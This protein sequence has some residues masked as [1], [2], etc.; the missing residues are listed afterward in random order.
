MRVT[1]GELYR[2]AYGEFAL[3]AYN[4]NNM[5]Q[6][7]GLFEGHRRAEAPFIV[8]ISRGALRYAGAGMLDAMIG[9]AAERYP[10]LIFATHLDHGDEESCYAAIDS[11]FFTSIMIDA[12]HEPFDDNVA[13]TKRVV[14]RAHA[15]GLSVE[16]ELG[17][18]GGVE[19]DI[20][21]D[22]AHAHL[23]DPGE[24]EVFVK[25]TGCDS[26]AVAVGTSHGAYKFRGEQG[27]RLERIRAI[28]ERLPHF[29]LVLH[30][31]SSVPPEEVRRINEAGGALDP[32]A[33][34]V[35]LEEL[36]QAIPLGICKVNVDT[37]GRL[38]WT[39]VHREHFRDEPAA[40][41]L[42]K[43]GQLFMDEF[44]EFVAERAREF[45]ASGELE[46]V[47]R[48]LEEARS[49]RGS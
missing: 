43:P 44:A 6:I 41:D 7:L 32:G 17:L 47:R 5:E 28:Q 33:R 23:T 21:V 15:A 12:S 10:E 20:A 4:V 13:I 34:G 8:A 38:I 14:E 22:E 18:L 35:S 2:I 39:R 46:R 36:R 49:G 29:P 1:T 9:A 19:E 11:G 37:D 30:G 45:G 31:S 40:I 42:R 27:L 26:L 48:E 3:G 16:A 24:A 25:A